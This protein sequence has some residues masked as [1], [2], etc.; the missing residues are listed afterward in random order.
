MRQ[1]TIVRRVLDRLNGIRE[2]VAG[3][4]D[5]WQQKRGLTDDELAHKAG[6]SVELL[7]RIQGGKLEPSRGTRRKIAKAVGVTVAELLK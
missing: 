7:K 5:H 3:R 2:G 1:R 4:V 6:I